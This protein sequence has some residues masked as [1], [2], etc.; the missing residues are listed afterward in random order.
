MDKKIEEKVQVYEIGYLLVASLP[1]EKVASEVE[2]LKSVLSKKGVEFI[3]EEIPELRPLAYSM[4]KK[5]GTA[6][7]KFDKGY[8]GWFKF[9]AKAGDI[10][11][12]K[13]SFEENPH[14]LRM[15]LISTIKENTYLGKKS[16]VPMP[17]APIEPS[18][19]NIA[20]DTLVVPASVED[21]DK[22]ID[23]LVKEA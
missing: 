22:S 11:D 10:N 3:G 8:F 7:H 9:E 19:E 4:V 12:I 21:M 15:L 5:I 20:T 18:V 6:N 13:K 17:E 23:A 1:E 14:M 16:P 2:N